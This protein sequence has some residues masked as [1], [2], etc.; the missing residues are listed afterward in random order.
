MAPLREQARA[1]IAAVLPELRS[2]YGA[3]I[4]G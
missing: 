3:P 1:T 2:R 4:P